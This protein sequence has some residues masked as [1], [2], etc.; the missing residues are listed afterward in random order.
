M[1]T[2]KESHPFS[3]D[4]AHACRENY[5]KDY[6]GRISP[7]SAR[8]LCGMYPVPKVGNETLVALRPN[9]PRLYV[10]NISGHFVLRSAQAR[11]SEWPTMFG[12]TFVRKPSD[13]EILAQIAHAFAE[14]G[15]I[16][17]KDFRAL[18]EHEATTTNDRAALQR[19]LYGNAN[20]TPGG[21]VI[22]GCDDYATVRALADYIE[23]LEG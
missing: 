14:S 18:S 2:I 7:K 20:R 1:I 11:V 21:Q 8:A 3:A 6:M 23:K 12:V 16:S 13:N 17:E 5:G 19:I 4:F 22:A 10:S 9:G 15:V